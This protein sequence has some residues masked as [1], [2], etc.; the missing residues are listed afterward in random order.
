MWLLRREARRWC[1]V[2]QLQR[3]PPHDP[4]T[5]EMRTP[6]IRIR[7][8]IDGSDLIRM[9]GSQL[10]I[11]HLDH[12]LPGQ[13]AENNNHPVYVNGI[14]W[15]PQFVEGNSD[16][17]LLSVS[18]PKTA[19]PHVLTYEVRDWAELLGHPSPENNHTMT[20]LL[21]DAPDGAA[22]YEFDVCW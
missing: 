4:H 8:W 11:E 2:S 20:L 22:W 13:V 12:Q 3:I 16:A 5:A 21:S 19:Q 1:I 15:F 14:R 17:L 6:Q 9:R 18:L 10:W 7:A